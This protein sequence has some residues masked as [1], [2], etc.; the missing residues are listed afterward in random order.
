MNGGNWKNA[1]RLRVSPSRPLAPPP[2]TT[3]TAVR[4]LISGRSKARKASHKKIKRRSFRRDPKRFDVPPETK[5]TL[6]ITARPR[7]TATT[8]TTTTARTGGSMPLE[9]KYAFRLTNWKG[10]E[11]KNRKKRQAQK[12]RTKN[13]ADQRDRVI[14]RGHQGQNTQFVRWTFGARD[15]PRCGDRPTCLGGSPDGSGASQRSNGDRSILASRGD[16]TETFGGKHL[17]THATSIAERERGRETERAWHW[18]TSSKSR[19]SHVHLLM[20]W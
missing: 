3:K 12:R 6:A 18:W 2:T 20:C 8:T 19:T 4:S 7:S 1:C 9:K 13:K 16:R 5:S 10:R 17:P 11:F 15:R 14:T